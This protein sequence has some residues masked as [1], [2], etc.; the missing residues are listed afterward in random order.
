MSDRLSWP[1]SAARAR[2]PDMAT[3][4]SAQR[5]APGR[6]RARSRRP[7][8]P[9]AL[10]GR[11]P[12]PLLLLSVP[13]TSHHP[14][15]TAATTAHPAADHS[16]KLRWCCAGCIVSSPLTLSH[17]V[18]DP[19]I[20]KEVWPVVTNEEALAVSEAYFGHS[21]TAFKSS[22]ETVDLTDAHIDACA[23]SGRVCDEHEKVFA[24]PVSQVSTAATKGLLVCEKRAGAPE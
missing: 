17:N 19:T 21:G 4:A 7:A 14:Q 13:A 22:T 3:F 8:R 15:P 10:P 24:A 18:N 16:D 1:P 6:L 5:H 11:D 23:K 12:H 2:L 20:S 9:G